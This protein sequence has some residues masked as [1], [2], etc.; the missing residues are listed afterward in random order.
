MNEFLLCDLIVFRL[1]VKSWCVGAAK[2]TIIRRQLKQARV[3]NRQ[4]VCD[5]WAKKNETIYSE[6]AFFYIE[7]ITK[8]VYFMRNIK[9][10]NDSLD[11]IPQCIRCLEFIWISLYA[12]IDNFPV[13]P[14]CNMAKQFSVQTGRLSF[15]FPSELSFH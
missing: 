2:W 13:N 11:I 6:N 4:P 1:K 10:S 3:Y 15:Y 8:T 7:L 14:F 12:G 9:V 5:F